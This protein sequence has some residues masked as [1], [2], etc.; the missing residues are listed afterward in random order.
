M[1]S[2]NFFYVGANAG[3]P[4]GAALPGSF[5]AAASCFSG[6]R[7][8]IASHNYTKLTITTIVFLFYVLEASAG[9]FKAERTIPAIY[10]CAGL[11]VD[12]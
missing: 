9:C 7:P 3:K 8:T 1:T 6:Q 11:Y 5:R 12:V 2:W 10:A 4:E